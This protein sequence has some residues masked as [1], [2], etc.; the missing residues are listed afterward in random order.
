MRVIP[1]GTGRALT[2]STR[3]HQQAASE[4]DRA[5]PANS[6]VPTRTQRP[7]SI[8]FNHPALS[9]EDEFDPESLSWKESVIKSYLSQEIRNILVVDPHEIFLALFTKSL[10][11]MIPHAAVATARS[12]EEGMTRIEAA[13]KAFPLSDGGAVHGF[14]I[15]IVEERL[16]SSSFSVQHLAGP[17]TSLSTHSISTQTAGDDS[18]QRRWSSLLSGTALIRQLVE[19]EKRLGINEGDRL[20]RSLIVGVSTRLQDHQKQLEGAGADCVWGKPPPEMNHELKNHLLMKLMN[21]RN[22]SV[23]LKLFD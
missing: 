11:H 23:D 22:S 1:T 9:S 18:I 8:L 19:Y 20:R 7:G 6:K 17:H 3:G 2:V 16:R 14:D 15:V 5:S 12:A 10:K 4:R 13:R 21:K